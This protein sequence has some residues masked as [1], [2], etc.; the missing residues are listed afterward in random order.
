M[1][2]SLPGW[3]DDLTDEN[4]LER[5]STFV[6]RNINDVIAAPQNEGHSFFDPT[7]GRG[8]PRHTTVCWDAY[9]IALDAWYDRPADADQAA[10]ELTTRQVGFKRTRAG[11]KPVTVKCRQQDEYCEWHTER[12]GDYVRK[13][14][15]TSESAD[16]W[17][18]LAEEDFPRVLELYR[19]LLG[20][21]DIEEADLLWPDDVWVPS[22]TSPS[23]WAKRFSRGQYNIWN[24]FNTRSGAVHTTHPDNT[25]VKAAMLVAGA[26]ILRSSDGDELI[27]DTDALICAAG[28]GDPN[29]ASDPAVGGFVNTEVRNRREVSVADP[30][31]V[32]MTGLRAGGFSGPN[33]EAVEG[34]WKPKRGTAAERMVLRAVFKVP[35]GLDRVLLD[36]EPVTSGA[37]IARCIRMNSKLLIRARLGEPP[38]PQPGVACCVL[39][40]G[41]SRYR[42]VLFTAIDWPRPPNGPPAELPS[43]ATSVAAS[44]ASPPPIAAGPTEGAIAPPPMSHPNPSQWDSGVLDM[45]AAGGGLQNRWSRWSMFGRWS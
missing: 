30:V 38:K 29:R 42:G 25:L 41:S 19:K 4:Q 1:S 2:Y 31:G 9:P 26:S 22:V 27:T 24:K 6:A 44:T 13:V 35:A 33:G 15:F 3:V 23:G 37:Q 7:D 45:I 43:H 17:S 5:W 10:E 39:R 20:R 12:D 14:T 34:L 32:Y 40:P 11:I 18:F 36:G 16:Y 8:N 28:F 21:K